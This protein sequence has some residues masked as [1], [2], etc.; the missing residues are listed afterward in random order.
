[1]SFFYSPSEVAKKTALVLQIV[2]MRIR[3]VPM[4]VVEAK[5]L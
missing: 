2:V 5:F 4:K 3:Q 1:L